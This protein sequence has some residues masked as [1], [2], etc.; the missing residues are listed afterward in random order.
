M[1]KEIC[2]GKQ[3]KL[4][5]SCLLMS[6]K[7][8]LWFVPVYLMAIQSFSQNTFTCLLTDAGS[9]E[10]LSNVSVLLKSTGKGS[11]SDAN[12]K[13]VLK[14]ISNGKHLLIFS[15]IGYKEQILEFTFPLAK[16]DSAITISMESEEKEIEQVIISSSRTDTRIENTPTRVEVLGAEEVDEESGVKPSH[17]ASLL[18]DVA[19]IQS[20]QTSAVSGNTELRIQGLPGN[21]TQ[22]LRDGMPLFGGYAGSFSIL[23]IPPLD[24]KQI[25]IIKGASSTLYGGGA[26]AGMI[27]IISKKP[28]PGVKERSLMINQTSLQETNLNIYLSE[29]TGKM[30]FSFFSGANYQKQKDINNDGFTDV[31]RLEGAFIHTT[32]YYYPNEKNTVSLGVNSNYEDRI[33]GDIEVVDGYPSNFHQ[34]YIQNQTYRNTLDL[35]WD[36]KISKTDHFMFKATTSNFNR[37]ITTHIFGMKARQRSYFSEASY[38]KKSGKHDVVAGI[39]F[40]GENLKKRLPDSTLISNFNF[41]TVGFFLQDDWRIHPKLTLQSGLRSD[42]HNIYKAFVLPRISLLYKISHSVNMRLG[43]GLGYKIPTVFDSEVD[44]RDYAKLKPLT[45]VKAERSTGINWDVNFKKNIGK[46]GL[47]LNQSFYLTQI[48]HPLLLQKTTSTISYFNAAKPLST[49]GFETWIQISFEGLE[50]YLG[51]TLTDARK[52][53]DPVHP[54]LD[55]SARNKF[56]SV[57]SY[58]FSKRFRA[59]I[60]AAYTGK[61]YLEDGSQTPSF[62]FVAGMMR[63]DVGRFS[64]VLNCENILDYRQTKKESIVIPPYTN[65]TFK[66]LWAPIDG[67]VAN[68]SI[69]I[70]L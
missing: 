34:F 43:G 53:Y 26:I 33:G 56:A 49:K 20:Q 58:E 24:I 67:R 1:L 5:V 18:G 57:I 63:Y 50:A 19:G 3:H 22:I 13:L 23:Q 48:E 17:I 59:C 38:V 42:F 30:G 69:K 39:N 68:L 11:S 41:F 12:G 21:Y 52:K 55:L 70:K 35:V 66:Q 28:K 60:E 10:P 45:N 32:L 29:R 47:T 64:F 15:S 6:M 4:V 62:P 7:K 65:P 51:Y 54:Y 31:G 27:N 40:T 36:N 37:N 44:E 46:V 16:S 9:G 25:E 2:Y 61:Q 8:I 14:N